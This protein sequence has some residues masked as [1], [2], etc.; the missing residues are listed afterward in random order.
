M[1]SIIS[2]N[3]TI[4]ENLTV[5]GSTQLANFAIQDDLIIGSNNISSTYLGL[6]ILS[7]NYLLH[8]FESSSANNTN[9]N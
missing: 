8:L 5:L 1:S 3:L 6:G 4:L 9:S 7:P 2:G